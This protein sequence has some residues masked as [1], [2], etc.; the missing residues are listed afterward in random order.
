MTDVTLTEARQK[1]L[2]AQ[3]QIQEAQE[4]M[5]G[6][7]KEALAEGTAALF[8]K[9]PFLGAIGWTQY[10]PYFND[11]DACVFSTSFTWPG[12]NSVLDVENEDVSTDEDGGEDFARRSR[13]EHYVRYD[14][15][16]QKSVYA[17]N[18]DYD[19]EYGAC[20]EEVRAFCKS[21]AGDEKR[22]YSSDVPTNFDQALLRAFGDHVQVTIYRDGK[23]VIDEYYHD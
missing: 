7:I 3:R 14:R 6:A 4:V 18:P 22:S 11:G 9:Y 16:A 23:I 12:L 10:T 20:A 5:A 19:P 1:A 13:S 15:E 17:P 21:L 8:E 2:Y